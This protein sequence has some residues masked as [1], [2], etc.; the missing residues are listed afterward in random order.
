MN[1]KEFL[2]GMG[3]ISIFPSQQPRIKSDLESLTEDWEKVGNDMKIAMGKK[4]ESPSSLRF[5][6]TERDE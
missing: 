4:E 2:K 6:D 1:L 3:S 5:L